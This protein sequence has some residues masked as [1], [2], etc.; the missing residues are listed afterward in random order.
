MD[1]VL[2]SSGFWTAL[3]IGPARRSART[4]HGRGEEVVTIMEYLSSIYAGN[5]NF[6]QNLLDQSGRGEVYCVHAVGTCSGV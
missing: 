6:R 2:K 4:I 5:G 3:A 1:C